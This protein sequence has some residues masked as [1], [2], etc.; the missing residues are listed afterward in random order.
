MRSASQPCS[1][2]CIERLNVGLWHKPYMRGGRPCPVLGA[3][4]KSD[5]EKGNVGKGRGT[6]ALS[7]VQSHGV[8]GA[9][10]S[11]DVSKSSIF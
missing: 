7:E 10:L 4:L 5:F 6:F 3:K 2:D 1:E 8:D 9:L 11:S